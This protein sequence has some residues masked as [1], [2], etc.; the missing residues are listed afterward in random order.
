MAEPLPISVFIEARPALDHSAELC[1]LQHQTERGGREGSFCLSF[2]RSCHHDA[3]DD[4]QQ[5]PYET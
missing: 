2:C 5:T 3:D 1:G 4:Q